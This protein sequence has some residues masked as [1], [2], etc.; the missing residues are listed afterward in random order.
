[1]SWDHGFSIV[2]FARDG[3]EIWNSGENE[4]EDR[5]EQGASNA[6]GKTGKPAN[7]KP[8]AVIDYEA[9]MRRISGDPSFTVDRDDW[10]LY[11]KPSRSAASARNRRASGTHQKARPRLMQP[12]PRPR[13]VRSPPPPAAVRAAL[14][15]IDEYCAL[16]YRR[17]IEPKVPRRFAAGVEAAGGFFAWVALDAERRKRLELACRRFGVTPAELMVRSFSRGR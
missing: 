9:R 4:F 3:K 13:D 15:Y 6:R 12:P 11:S 7:G 14:G 8:Q 2:R 16:R 10:D 1:M 17:G 5:E